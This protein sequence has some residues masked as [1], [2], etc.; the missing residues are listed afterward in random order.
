MRHDR[1]FPFHSKIHPMTSNEAQERL[2]AA[3][4]RPTPARV[5]VVLVL[6]TADAPMTASDVLRAL[7]RHGVAVCLATAS[8]ALSELVTADVLLRT[9]VA[10]HFGA[11]AMYSLKATGHEGRALAHR[12]ICGRC[13]HSIAFIDPGLEERLCRAAGLHLSGRFRQ[14]LAVTVACLGCSPTCVT[15]GDGTSAVNARPPAASV[16][17]DSKVPV[18]GEFQQHPKEPEKMKIRN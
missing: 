14:P 4:L 10:G 5:H 17:M 18:A 9:W 7:T 2:R 1:L 8:R 6:G 13:G 11:K 3:R 16:K 12:L 15:R